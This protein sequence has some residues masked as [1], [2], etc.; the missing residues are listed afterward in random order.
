MVDGAAGTDQPMP[1]PEGELLLVGNP[2]V[3]KSAL[4]GE[5]TGNYVVVSNYPGTTVEVTRGIALVGDRKLTVM[6]SPGA[7]SFLPSSDD[8][9]V[10]RDM[11]LSEETGTVV[12]VGDAKNTQRTILLALQLEEMQRPY[13][14]C[15]NMMDEAQARGI[16]IDHQGLEAE[17]GID[18]VPTVATR[19][20]GTAALRAVLAAAR[21]GTR[22]IRYPERV[23]QALAEVIP[24]LPAA[25]VSPRALGLMVLCD[26]GSLD[27]WLAGKAGTA[28][29]SPIAGIRRRLHD[30]L[31]EPLI[32]VVNRTRLEVASEIVGRVESKSGRNSHAGTRIWQ[33]LDRYATHRF[34]GLP[35][36]GVV[37][38]AMYQFVGVFGAGTLVGI[39]EE[40]LFGSIINPAAIAF[41]DRWITVS[42]IRD[43]LVGEYGIITM[44]LTY[45]L[46][47]VFPIVGTFFLAF[48]LLEDSGYLPRLAVMVNKGF[49]RIGLNGKA[50][51][52][53]VLGLGCDTMATLTTRILETRKERLIVIL[54]LALGVPC[55][56]QLTVILAMLGALSPLA[57]LIWVS[58]VLGVILLV[59]ALASKLIPGRASD[60]IL[61]LPPL[62]MPRPG[63]I[64]VKTVARIE[65]YLKEAVPLFVLGTV[66]LFIVDR[67]NWL[68][69][70][71]R[72]AEPILKGVLGL[73]PETAGTFIIGFLRRDFGV[74]GLYHMSR[75][76]ALDPV[77]V[78]VAVTTITLFIPC[79]ANLFMIVKER[80]WKTGLA[81]SA[82][83]FPFALLV[84]ALLN[85]VLRAIPL[86]LA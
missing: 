11:L 57:L 39:L 43:F 22:T 82:F 31:D 24:L 10:T 26:D 64:L 70:M 79:I 51:L 69:A 19:G 45:S 83:I 44:A 71:E 4:F 47:L 74:A 37:L 21:C 1:L 53:M 8:E 15:L 23:E 16:E 49:R 40:G 2:N 27:D 34:W 3:G 50:V 6:D 52:P 86:P 48:G 29:M 75:D 85:A 60:F 67:L 76:G 46:A 77:Q 25:P 55:S 35:I 84:G 72:A 66:I 20:K 36:L 41:A 81:I 56:A 32:Y 12:A 14:L 33:F 30:D 7:N 54:L 38:F 13:V 62:R 28:D 9:R 42:W 78:L 58:V 17:L 59:G 80:G 18:I 61:E 65:W 73:P 68:V 63:N 5:L